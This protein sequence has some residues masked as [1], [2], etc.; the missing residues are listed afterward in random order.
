MCHCLVER[1]LGWT[2][3][4]GRHQVLGEEALVVGAVVFLVAVEVALH[5]DT[6]QHYQI[7]TDSLLV[8]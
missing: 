7:N 1:R 2:H 8:E 5:V 4:Q 3:S 6:A